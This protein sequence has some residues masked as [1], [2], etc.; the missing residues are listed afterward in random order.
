[1]QAPG[2]EVAL[3]GAPRSVPSRGPAGWLAGG[4][5]LGARDMTDGD[6][7]WGRG[8]PAGCHGARGAPAQTLIWADRRLDS[9][10][11]REVETSGGR[12]AGLSAADAPPASLLTRRPGLRSRLPAFCKS[13]VQEGRGSHYQGSL[14]P[15]LTVSC[16][17]N[18]VRACPREQVHFEHLRG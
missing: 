17:C 2:P 4:G 12:D 14:C 1:M 9:L 13:A 11:L 3:C 7:D 16:V 5:R 6:E 8:W 18:R 10:D 15:G